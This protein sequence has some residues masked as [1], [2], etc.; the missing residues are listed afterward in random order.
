MIQNKQMRVKVMQIFHILRGLF[1]GAVNH[2]NFT[3]VFDW[4]YP[5]FFGIVKKCLTVYSEPCDDEVVLLIFKLLH[6]LVDN[7][8]NRLKFDAWSINGLIVYKESASFM[9]EF[10]QKFQCLSPQQ[11]KP[12]KQNDIYKEIYKYLK[13]FVGMMQSFISGRY[14]NFAI[15]EYYNDQTFTH[16]SQLVFQCII[17]QDLASLQGYNKLNRKLYTFIEEFFKHHLELIFLRFDFNLVMQV[18][19]QAL[20]PGLTADLVEVKSSA[21][22]TIDSLNTFVFDNLRRPSKKQPEMAQNVQK[23]YAQYQNV[24]RQFLRSI[25]YTLLFEDH[26]NVWIFQ[27]C[28]HSS[29]V[30]C[31]G[32]A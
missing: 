30:M 25:A 12:L 29:I 23:F 7:S 21:L 14:I 5:E 2:K 1:R 26:Q 16:V 4:F 18:V 22:S 6:E 19:D 3:L 24:F 20:V 8:S 27:R 31:E 13:V 11:G 15:C 28:L 9:I 17:S 32:G 10:M